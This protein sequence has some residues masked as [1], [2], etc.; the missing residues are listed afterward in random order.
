MKCPKCDYL[1]FETGDTCKNCGYD[2]SL[3]G[4][5]DGDPIEVDLDLDLRSV[6]SDPALVPDSLGT[7]E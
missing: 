7:L 1:G 5:P 6:D 3:I 4:D 2:F